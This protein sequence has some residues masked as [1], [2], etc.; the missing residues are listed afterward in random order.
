MPKTPEILNRHLLSAEEMAE[1]GFS[2]EEMH[3]R[4]SN[5]Q[6]RHYWRFKPGLQ[7]V[8]L[9][10]PMLDDETVLLIRE[11]AAG[12]HNYQLQLPKGALEEGEELLPAANRELMEEVGKGARRLE[13]INRFTAIPGFNP[14]VTDVVLAQ[15]LYDEKRKGDEPE[16]MEVVPWSLQNL[17]ELVE[18]QDCTEARSIA[19]L[20][21]V[22]EL[23]ANR[24]V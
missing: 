18:R 23:L 3:L 9:V 11:Y 6:E 17:T 16:E 5:Q 24:Q 1:R 21:Y 2:I 7:G 10:V 20:Y 4:F 14:Q 22:R 13:H 8:V 15:D 19:A 12:T